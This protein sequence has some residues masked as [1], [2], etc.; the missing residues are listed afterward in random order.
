MVRPRHSTYPMKGNPSEDWNRFQKMTTYAFTVTDGPDT[1]RTLTLKVG[2]T[3]LG[4]LGTRD[5]DDFRIYSWVVND[6][7]VSRTHAEIGLAESGE[8]ILRHISETNATF[9][10]G[11][12]IMRETLKPGQTIRI[13]QT[14]I[15]MDGETSS[16][17][18]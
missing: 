1:G 13:G 16:S 14:S 18:P 8:P 10:D 17:A 7:T 3:Y 6:K 4:R 5:D 12:S 15:R 11:R 9:V 2:T